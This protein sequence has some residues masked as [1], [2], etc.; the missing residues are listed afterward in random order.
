M[1]C[2]VTVVVDTVWVLS[3]FILEFELSH[4]NLLSSSLMLISH[5]TFLCS[6]L[7]RWKNGQPVENWEA[8]K[9]AI[10]AVTK[11]P[12]GELVTGSNSC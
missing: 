5:W 9:A 12:S 2:K 10:Q 11:L 8:H 4:L 3:I 6:T 1:F 7:R